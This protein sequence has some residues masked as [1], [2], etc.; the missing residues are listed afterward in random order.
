M[1]KKGDLQKEAQIHSN[2]DQRMHCDYGNNTLVHP[3]DW[4]S[5]ECVAMIVYQWPLIAMPV[6][7]SILYG[8]QVMIYCRVM[9]E[10]LG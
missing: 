10:F 2:A 7:L 5:P 3:P 6:T 4:H 9:E 8:A 1:P